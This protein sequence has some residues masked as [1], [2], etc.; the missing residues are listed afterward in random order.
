MSTYRKI[1]HW[2]I[3]YLHMIRGHIFAAVHRDPPEHYLGYALPDKVP[4]ILIPGI[5]EKWGFMKPIADRIS[6]EGHPVYV[7][8][9]LQYNIF[10]IPLSAQEVREVVVRAI[11]K[12]DFA[13]LL[14]HSKGG[15]IGKYLLSHYND[16]G[17]IKGMVAIATPFSGA[18]LAKFIPHGAFQELTPESKIIHDLGEHDAVNH[19]IISIIPKFDNHIL[20]EKGSHL[21]G[22]ENIVVSESGHH[23]VLF[24]K[25]VEDKV[26]ESIEKIAHG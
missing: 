20:G 5:L 8:P 23:K 15:L 16:D 26:L 17:R 3:D 7:V 24:S 6:R 21:Q 12:E 13:V 18:V 14:A 1:R 10:S 4:V 25:E 19:K 9:G 2:I 22:A 11:P